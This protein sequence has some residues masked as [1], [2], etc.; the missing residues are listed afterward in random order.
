MIN[1][2]RNKIE[3]Y[4]AD[5]G[6][7]SHVSLRG[8]ASK[9]DMQIMKIAANLHIADSSFEP[10]I[11][12]K[13]VISAIA[14]AGELIEANLKLC[15]DKGI[16]GVKAEFTSILALFENDQRP[17]NERSITQGKL[18]TKPFKEFTGNK[19]QLIIDTLAE[20]VGQKLLKRSVD[21]SGKAS[22]SPA[23]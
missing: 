21:P 5:G 18:K 4:L 14:I 7:Y 2:Y 3:P 11:P 8:A 20:M 6:R 19:S 12:D 22:Y 15:Q 9:I 17:R 13:H 16:M 1:E 23:Q 10:S